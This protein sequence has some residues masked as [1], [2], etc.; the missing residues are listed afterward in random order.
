MWNKSVVAFH[1][2]FEITS[3]TTHTSLPVV[4]RMI[5]VYHDFIDDAE[6]VLLSPP[7]LR[8]LPGAL[9]MFKMVS[10]IFNNGVLLCAIYTV[11][12]FLRMLLRQ[13]YEILCQKWWN[14]TVQSN[15]IWRIRLY[16]MTMHH[17]HHLS[18]HCTKWYPIERSLS[19]RLKLIYVS[20]TGPCRCLTKKNVFYL[21][22]YSY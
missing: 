12:L 3:I 1:C 8:V 15:F 22:L 11:L 9:L 10:S 20:E 16:L 19:L 17:Y 13:F 2:L 14:K 18:W 21:D 4:S 5:N 6:R 7:S